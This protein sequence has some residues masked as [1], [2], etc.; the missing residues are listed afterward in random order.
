M[1]LTDSGPLVAFF[2]R[3]DV[4]HV[5][6]VDAA[7]SLPR[8]PLVTTLASVTEAMYCFAVRQAWK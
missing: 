6:C 7:K 4:N 2:N 1:I 5:R 8:G 3:R